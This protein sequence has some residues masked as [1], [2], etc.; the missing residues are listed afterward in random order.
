MVSH[1]L[2]LGT[3][4]GVASLMGLA[5]AAAANELVDLGGGSGGQPVT[6]TELLLGMQKVSATSG[7]FDG[8]LSAHDRFGS[9]LAALGDV[10]GDGVDDLAVG[11]PFDDDGGG[12][13]NSDVGAVWI[14]LRHADGSVRESIK[15]SASEGGWLPALNPGDGFGAAVA[16]LGDL[17]G[18]GVP[19]LAVGAPGDDDGGANQQAD[20]GAVYILLL[21]PDGQVK[22]FRKLSQTTGDLGAGLSSGDGFGS[23]LAAPGDMGA[24]G[25]TELV[26][27]APF[28]DAAGEDAGAVWILD[29]AADGSVDATTRIDGQQAALAELEAGDWFGWSVTGLSDFDQDGDVDL[30]VGAIGDDDG[31][32]NALSNRGAVWILFLDPLGGVDHAAKLSSQAG[33]AE[34]ELDDTDYFGSSVA[35]IGGE[36]NRLAVGARFDDDGALNVGAVYLLELDLDGSVQWSVKFSATQGDFPGPLA[37]VDNFGTALAAVGDVGGNA[38]GDLAIG[39]P[40]DEDA[41]GPDNSGA[42]WELFLNEPDAL[43]IGDGPGAATGTTIRFKALGTSGGAGESFALDL[44]VQGGPPGS[45][46]V[47]VLGPPTPGLPVLGQI[48]IPAPDLVVGLVL[49]G[50]GALDMHV[51]LPGGSI[52]PGFVGQVWFSD[53]HAPGGFSASSAFTLP[54]GWVVPGIPGPSGNVEDMLT[55]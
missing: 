21:Q 11:A 20:L 51:E 29:L 25:L 38:F 15:I 8:D 22:S 6:P 27:G 3:V 17:D 40:G 50:N 52:A 2:M 48:L 28:D 43:S 23:A 49:D 14:L 34:L 42:V 31:G 44:T 54:F 33:G 30:A 12:L 24:D 32:A 18:D 1:K 55:P 19:D 53:E 10:D 39:A 46:G 36:A 7:G 16:G 41:G 47:L 37:A 9:S 35:W 4:M 45:A 5:G 13:S 26:V